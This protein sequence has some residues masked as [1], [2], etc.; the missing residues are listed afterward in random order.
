MCATGV[1]ERSLGWRDTL[2]GHQQTVGTR[3][4]DIT[5]RGN[6]KKR[7]PKTELWDTLLLT[8]WEKWHPGKEGS[9]ERGVPG[10]K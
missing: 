4:Y 9:P 6:I 8:C 2:G 10:I 7:G 1:Q 3:L 5:K